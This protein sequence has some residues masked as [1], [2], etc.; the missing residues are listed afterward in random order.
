MV[1][2]TEALVVWMVVSFPVVILQHL[3]LVLHSFIQTLFKVQAML[4]T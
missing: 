2:V 3:L 4:L 1:E